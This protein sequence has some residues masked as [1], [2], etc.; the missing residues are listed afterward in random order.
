M[1][2]DTSSAKRTSKSVEYHFLFL[3]FKLKENSEEILSV[4]LL[5]PACYCFKVDTN[6]CMI[7][8]VGGVLFWTVEGVAYGWNFSDF[9]VQMRERRN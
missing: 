4:A 2:E 3:S 8:Q 5:S 6:G 7:L 9:C 1:M